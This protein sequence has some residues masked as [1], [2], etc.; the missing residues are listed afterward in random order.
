MLLIDAIRR[1]I[2]L[3]Q[4]GRAAEAEILCR[5]I[6]VNLPAQPEACQIL[7]HL[8]MAT[9][10]REAAAATLQRAARLSPDSS[11]VRN[12]LGLVRQ[13]LGRPAEAA[14]AQERA[15]ALDPASP[16]ALINRSA[17]HLAR[18][19]RAGA[20]RDLERVLLL[21]PGDGLALTNLGICLLGDRRPDRAAAALRR[22]AAL[23]PEQAEVLYNLGHALREAGRHREALSAYDRALRLSPGRSDIAGY[24]LFLKQLCCDWDGYE[25]LCRRIGD[26][27]D[28][29]DGVVLPLA[30]LSIDISAAQ[31]HRA[32]ALFHDRMV[33]GRMA[34]GPAPAV[35]PRP[36]ADPRG[37][38][39]I[40]YFSADFHQHATAHL[41][42][43]LFE[44]HDRD[45]FE[46]TAWS[47]GPDDGSAMRQRLVG[48]F[49][50][51]IDIRQAPLETVAR[52]VAALGVDILVDL[53]GYTRDA[54]LDLLSRRLAPVQVS[55]LGYPGTLACPHMDYLIGDRIVTPPDHQPFYGERLV[56]M[57]DSYQVND[58][59]RP[60]DAP[61]PSRA[62]C[63]LPEEGIVFCAFNATYK[64]AP[65]MFG[66]WMRILDRVPG[67]VLWL[68]ETNPEAA[69]NLRREAAARGVDPARLVFAP[70]L[71]QAEH[72]ARYRLADLCLDTLP[73]TGHTTTS[74]ALWMGCPVVTLIGRSFAGRVAASLLTAAGLPELV[75]AGETAYEETALR[76]ARSPQWRAS[77]RRRLERG[78]ETAPLF[79]SRR[80][81][82]HL[83]EAYRSMWA[84]RGEGRPPR[85]FAVP[86]LPA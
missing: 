84:I 19:D 85:G 38:L 59:R 17:L 32:A 8:Q 64:I 16:E 50:R 40:A 86:R 54:R 57:P 36:P 61:V 73:Y 7:G 47:Y 44:L 58:R 70:L 13:W 53:K 33:A 65:A 2:A 72:L 37:R 1:A 18:G 41:A 29:G 35:W 28:G 77:L 79:D 80:F 10:R 74:D 42:A 78:R 9:G 46:V 68:F 31:Q 20:I 26:A 4:A 66:L 52:H 63:G 12:H 15:L 67:S 25:A 45:R 83:E 81:T 51:F 75:C 69:A 56:L 23:R 21:R 76:L 71:P 14:V 3:Q 30:T 62:S 55:Y 11:D 82:R 34:G 43:E 6:L 60:L 24:L 48:A 27:I 22:A 5:T 49:D 39:R